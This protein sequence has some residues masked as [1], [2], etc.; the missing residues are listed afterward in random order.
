MSR[1]AIANAERQI[2]TVTRGGSKAGTVDMAVY[3]PQRR[4]KGLRKSF[5]MVPRG[6]DPGSENGGEK[7]VACRSVRRSRAIRES[8]KNYGIVLYQTDPRV[9]GL[10]RVVVEDV[11]TSRLYRSPNDIVGDWAPKKKEEQAGLS[12][13]SK[14]AREI[15]E[16][17]KVD[18]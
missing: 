10:T 15:A 11:G 12:R 2:A 7:S 4:S 1:R 6:T 14:R 13:L 8:K 16:R 18:L 9:A 5:F 17:L 3:V